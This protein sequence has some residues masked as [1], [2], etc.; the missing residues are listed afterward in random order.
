LQQR[1]ARCSS[2]GW[3]RRA[4]SAAQRHTA[5]DSGEER[6]GQTPK[7]FP[8]QSLPTAD[9][10]CAWR[11]CPGL[12]MCSDTGKKKPSRKKPVAFVS[13]DQPIRGPKRQVNATVCTASGRPGYWE[14]HLAL[15]SAA[16]VRRAEAT[17]EP[18]FLLLGGDPCGEETEERV[19]SS[20]FCVR[21]VLCG[22]TR[23]VRRAA[24]AWRNCWYG[25]DTCVFFSLSKPCA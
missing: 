5:R 24:L 4:A 18:C 3:C 16:S 19:R 2:A 6:T 23:A 14:N 17:S 8:A 22:P 10:P 9:P 11:T 21:C 7:C 12:S 1:A 15:I 25:V 13:F 20:E